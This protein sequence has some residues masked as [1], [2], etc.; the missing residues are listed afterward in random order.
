[1]VFLADVM[2]THGGGTI[3]SKPMAMTREAPCW[4]CDEY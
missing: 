4:E 2:I 3:G 1:M